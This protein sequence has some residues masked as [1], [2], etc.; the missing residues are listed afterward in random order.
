MARQGRRLVAS[1]LGC[2]VTEGRYPSTSLHPAGNLVETLFGYI[3]AMNPPIPAAAVALT[4][5]TLRRPE[6][7][8]APRA[9]PRTV[10]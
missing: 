1:A 6:P 10:A 4:T 9:A 2:K 7:R 8:L 5:Q 3:S